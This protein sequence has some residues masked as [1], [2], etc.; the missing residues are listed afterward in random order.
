MGISSR[1][2]IKTIGIQE[3]KQAKH[4]DFNQWPISKNKNF[5][6]SVNKICKKNNVE[7]E[8]IISYSVENKEIKK[9]YRKY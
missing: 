2:I 3:N 5:V 7:N 1:Y 6:I 4:S 9:Q 8:K